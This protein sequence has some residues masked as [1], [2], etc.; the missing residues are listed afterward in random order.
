MPKIFNIKD[1]GAKGDGKTINTKAIQNAID[2]CTPNGKVVI[3]AGVFKSGAIFL[4]SNMT[5]EISGGGT[6]LGSER[7]EDYPLKRGYRLYTYSSAD[8]PPSLINALADSREPGAFTDIRIVGKGMID[9]NG[10]ERTSQNFI[11]D[12]A[13]K[14]LPQYPAVNDVS[15][16]MSFGILAKAQLFAVVQEGLD[17]QKLFGQRR[18]SLLTM[19]GVRNLY[20]ADITCVNPAFHGVMNLQCENVVMNGVVHKTYDI[21]NADGIEFG[22]CNNIMVFNNL[23][24]TGDDC[25]NFAA[26]TGSDAEKQ[27]PMQNAFI[28]NN[29]FREGHG[30]VVLGSHTGAW[31]QNI[32]AEDNIV[33]G[34]NVA[35]R[36]KSTL[37]VGGGGRNVMFRD[38]AVKNYTRQAYVFTLDYFDPNSLIDYKPAE[39]AGQFR[40]ITVQNNSVENIQTYF[41][42]IQVKGDIAKKAYHEN[43]SFINVYMK[44]VIGVK[45]DGLKG[46]HFRDVDF[47][48]LKDDSE[49]WSIQNSEGLA[50]EGITRKPK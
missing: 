45:I 11:I 20:Y 21:A 46:G 43:I 5:L 24:D 25:V 44:N 9:G 6:L 23:F 50:F 31:I 40:D 32:L 37:I 47:R 28:F 36:C 42:V 1:F 4:K 39:R 41:P 26:G 10:W 48:S 12:E 14:Q 34:T 2:A 16:A 13:G 38:T 3:P 18:S 17:P 49:P 15:A 19:R 8:R 35:L 27:Q 22:N 30:A 7:S 29:Y 33:N